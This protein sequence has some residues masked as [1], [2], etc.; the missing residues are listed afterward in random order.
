MYQLVLS[1]AV[2]HLVVSQWRVRHS[3]FD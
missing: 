3:A 2:D 1:N